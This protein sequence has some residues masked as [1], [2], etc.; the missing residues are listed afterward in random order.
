MIHWGPVLVSIMVAFF[1]FIISLALNKKGYEK[2]SYYIL[3]FSECAFVISIVFFLV[4][5]YNVYDG[6]YD[7]YLSE[8]LVTLILDDLL[9]AKG[10]G[11]VFMSMGITGLIFWILTNKWFYFADEGYRYMNPAITFIGLILGMI[12]L[13]GFT[14]VLKGFSLILGIIGTIIGILIGIKKLTDHKNSK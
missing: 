7:K 8:G 9:D 10:W 13:I 4:Q 5:V 3:F 6:V 12:F 1:L 2:G 14:D 11:I